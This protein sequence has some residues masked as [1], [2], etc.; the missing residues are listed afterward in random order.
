[1]A[2]ICIDFQHTGQV[3]VREAVGCARCHGCQDGTLQHSTAITGWMYCTVP[4]KGPTVMIPHIKFIPRFRGGL[5]VRTFLTRRLAGLVAVLHG[6]VSFAP[7][8][9]GKRF[10]GWEERA[11]ALALALVL[12]AAIRDFEMPTRTSCFPSPE[13]C[14][15]STTRH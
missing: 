5:L 9:E 10:E 14:G 2:C 13:L 6:C 4:L 12:A 15:P 11:L 7:S 8:G 3:P 1:M